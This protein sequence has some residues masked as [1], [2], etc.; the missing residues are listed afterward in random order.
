[1]LGDSAYAAVRAQMMRQ[2]R[3]FVQQLFELH[4]LCQV[5]ALLVSELEAEQ[6]LGGYEAAQH[7]P[8]G[9]KEASKLSLPSVSGLPRP[10]ASNTDMA[11]QASSLQ[12]QQQQEAAKTQAPQALASKQKQRYEQGKAAATPFSREGEA[13]G[14][15]GGAQ[16]AKSPI[17]GA[18]GA[19]KDGRAS[20]APTAAASGRSLQHDI[21]HHLLNIPASLRA[22]VSGST[23]GR[24]SPEPCSGP[25]CTGAGGHTTAGGR[26]CTSVGNPGTNLVKPQA[27]KVQPQQMAAA[28]GTAAGLLGLLPAAA[29]EPSVSVQQPPRARKS[30]PTTQSRQQ[31]PPSPGQPRAG[32]A[33]RQDSGTGQHMMMAQQAS[34][35]LHLPGADDGAATYNHLMAAAN[36]ILQV[37]D[38]VE[39]AGGPWTS[40]SSCVDCLSCKCRVDNKLW[41]YS[42]C[43]LPTHRSPT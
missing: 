36:A 30:A 2:Q 27:L 38:A 40:T 39:N 28:A 18:V 15:G 7:E 42:T 14:Q 1:M 17:S 4:K 29:P 10:P 33:A 37:G 21:Q 16:Q 43:V 19:A 20:T 11:W 32:P 3:V 25:A 26:D 5:Q 9:G 31:H 23:T 34:G 8:S 22:R 12:Q 41:C 13:V 35:A 24:P 6:E